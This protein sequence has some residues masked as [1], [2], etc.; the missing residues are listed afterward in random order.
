MQ[1]WTQ[2]YTPLGSLWLS[3]LAAAIPILFFFVALAVLR[4][5]GHVAAAIT[6]ALALAVAILAYGMPAPQAFAAAGYGFAYGLWPIAWII[7]T[8]GVA[9]E[10][11][12]GVDPA[13]GGYFPPGRNFL[14]APPPVGPSAA[15]A[16]T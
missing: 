5:K 13:P 16:A 8:A 10:D 4:M 9:R 14:R 6:L 1:P 7:V 2:I 15:G 12:T 11:Q 3:A